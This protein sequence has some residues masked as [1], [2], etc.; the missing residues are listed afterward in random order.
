[1]SGR[2]R[3][4]DV[5][6]STR[7]G[8]V[9]DIKSGGTPSTAIPE[10][11][12][13]GIPWCTPTDITSTEGRELTTTARTITREGL[14]ACGATLLPPGTLLLCS[15]ATVGHVK[16]ATASVATNQGFKSLICG[17]SV[18]H[19][20]LYYCLLTLADRM[21]DL[22]TG[23]TFLEITKRGIENLKIRLPSLV[24]Q[25]AIATVLSDLDELIESL[26]TLIAKKHDIKQGAMQ[27][28]LA[29][30]TRLPGFREEWEVRRLGDVA[31]LCMGQT[32]PRR[33]A[34]CWGGQHVWLCVADL[35]RKTVF[36]SKEHVSD[37]AVSRMGLVRRGTLLMSFKLSVG[38]VAF[39]GC[40]LYTN[41]AICHFENVM[42]DAGFLY[43][44]L[45][46]V[47]FAEY[48]RQAVKGV[49]LNS[50][51]LARIEILFPPR[52]EQRAISQV[53]SAM[54]D[55]IAAIEGRLEKTRAIK[56]GMMQ[57][58]L[59]GGIRLPIPE[60]ETEGVGTEKGERADEPCG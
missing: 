18:G 21:L 17:G 47:R 2:Q 45:Q 5:W 59:T 36:D 44:A 27:R 51:T 25:R 37:V 50:G 46:R 6:V 40:D 57:K 30:T 55:E 26:E 20:Y 48:G 41:E 24:E 53:L 34:S 29:G 10:Y 15:R 4:R 38:R 13:G 12:N 33:D 11:W 9:A 19:E 3:F 54:D 8:D 16:I 22:A 28:L 49:T 56:E 23:S 1:M 35:G 60:H 58:L 32:P 14:S 39:A 43:Y 42:A 52:S 31:E 7:L